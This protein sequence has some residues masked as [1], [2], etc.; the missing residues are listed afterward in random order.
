MGKLLN[1]DELYT[2]MTAIAQQAQEITA[3]TKQVVAAAKTTLEG[4]QSKDGPVQGMT[5]SVKQTMDDARSAMA[6]FAANMEALKHNFLV[7]GFFKGRGLL[8]PGANCRPRNIGRVSS[9]KAAIGRWSVCG[10]VLMC[11]SSRIRITQ[12]TNG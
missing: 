8:Q 10:C 6:G 3:N 7:R 2:R 9:R 4:F 11:C 1:D 5:A 12:R